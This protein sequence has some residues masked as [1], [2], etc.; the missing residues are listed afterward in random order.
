MSFRKLLLKQNAYQYQ[1]LFEFILLNCFNCCNSKYFLNVKYIFRVRRK[2]S[3]LRMRIKRSNH[4]FLD[5]EFL[6]PLQ[7]H[8][9]Q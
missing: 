2:T 9:F 7:I 3:I 8:I 1:Q 5:K 4:Y 6:I